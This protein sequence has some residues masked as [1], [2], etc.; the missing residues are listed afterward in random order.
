VTARLLNFLL[1]EDDV[2]HAELVIRSLARNRVSNAVEHLKDGE[3]ALAY[4]R[5]EGPWADRP[6]PDV[7]L[8]DLKL[9]RLDGHEVLAAIKADPNLRPIP[10]VVMTTSD[11]ESDRERAYAQHANSYLV[12]PVDFAKFRQMVNDL[13]LYWGVWNQSV[14]R[15]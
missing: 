7:I 14:E 8:L 3:E 13:S 10:V 1:V 6:R 11:A 9:P 2:D 12:K 15:R 4:L 5:R